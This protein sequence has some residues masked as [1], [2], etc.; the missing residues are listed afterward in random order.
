MFILRT[1]ELIN[2]IF[3]R[4]S[5]NKKK[6]KTK[7]KTDKKSE[8]ELVHHEEMKFDAKTKKSDGKKS[9]DDE[10]DIQ[11]FSENDSQ[12][13]ENAAEN[14]AQFV[15]GIRLGIGLAFLSTAL[16]GLSVD[17][18]FNVPIAIFIWILGALAAAIEENSRS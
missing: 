18:L 15:E 1:S 13:E 14:D 10:I 8:P 6:S 11:K 7:T 17:P 2:E 12:P 3:D 4:F 5:R 16:N 9:D